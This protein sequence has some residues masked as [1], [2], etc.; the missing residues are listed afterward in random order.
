[1]RNQHKTSYL[2]YL[3]DRGRTARSGIYKASVPTCP[4]CPTCAYTCEIA[5][6]AYTEVIGGR[7]DK[8]DR[9]DF[10]A[11]T[12]ET[13]ALPVPP[14]PPGVGTEFG[15]ER[16]GPWSLRCSS[17]KSTPTGL[18]PTFRPC[19]LGRWSSSPKLA[20]VRLTEARRHHDATTNANPGELHHVNEPDA[21][22]RSDRHG[23]G[24]GT[25]C[26]NE[27]FPM[28]QATSFEVLRF[29]ADRYRA[30]LRE[31]AHLGMAVAS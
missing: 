7:S 13:S 26:Q 12:A 9:W 10:Q 3:S 11:N 23:S 29:V 27:K 25:R 2:S 20:G 14:V 6:R 21:V 22:D 16:M 15:G 30:R 17:R 19:R 4:T 24:L 8:W 28:K 18:P 1:M 31:F 5:G